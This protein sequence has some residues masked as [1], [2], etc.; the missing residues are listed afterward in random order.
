[1]KY[2]ND[3]VEQAQTDLFKKCGSFFAFSGKQYNEAKKDGVKYINMGSGFIC[4]EENVEKIINELN[5]INKKGIAKDM[6]EN[7]KKAIIHREL[8]N[9]E[10]QISGTITACVEKLEEYPITKKEI[11]TEWVEYFQKCVENNWF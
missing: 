6:A 3:Y 7:G 1:M 11:R 4:P 5:D 10:C 2:L 8:A 9:H